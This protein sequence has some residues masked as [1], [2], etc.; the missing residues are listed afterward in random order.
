MER[1]QPHTNTSKSE[2]EQNRVN[3]F[4]VLMKRISHRSANQT[5]NIKKNKNQE[6]KRKA[7]EKYILINFVFLKAF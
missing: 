6:I 4:R 3:F 2:R 5:E 1:D 7:H